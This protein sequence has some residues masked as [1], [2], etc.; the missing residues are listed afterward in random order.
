M[1]ISS[2]K[3]LLIYS[4]RVAGTVGLMMAKIL[5][6]KDKKSLRSAI[7]LGIAMQLTNI[8][9]CLLYTSPSPRD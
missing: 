8:S 4:Y 6:V 2:K 9:S 3:D 5:N 7:D 1:E